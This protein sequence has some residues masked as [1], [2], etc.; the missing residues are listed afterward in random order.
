MSG[1][2]ELVLVY[3]GPTPEGEKGQ[4]KLSTNQLTAY[5][6]F[7]VKCASVDIGAV[8]TP[9]NRRHWTT[10][11]KYAHRQLRAVVTPSQTF[12]V[13]SSLPVTTSS[14]PA[15]PA[16]VLSSEL[17]IPRMVRGYRIQDRGEKRPL[18]IKD[19]GFVEIGKQTIV[20]IREY[21]RQSAIHRE[22]VEA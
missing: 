3:A 13:P 12:T 5:M 11:L 7:V 15:P 1:Q 20:G 14:T 16:I 8:S 4:I 9:A 2:A 21:V 10:E 18:Q 22:S 19:W 17:M 6:D